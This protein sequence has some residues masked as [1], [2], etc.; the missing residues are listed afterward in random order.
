MA[1]CNLDKCELEA[2]EGEDRCILHCQKG[3][4]PDD[5]HRVGFLNSFYEELI[6][7]IVNYIFKHI[8]DREPLQKSDVRQH[9]LG[10]LK[11]DVADFLRE[12]T[13]VFTQIFF[14]ERDSRDTFDYKPALDKIG[15]I[16]FNYC[17][18]FLSSLDLRS[19]KLFFQDCV[20]HRFWYLY[21]HQILENVNQVLY[22]MC[23]FK[24]D[25]STVA[26]DYEK[27]ELSNSIFCNCQFQK[28]I[29][30]YDIKLKGRL[31]RNIHK[32]KI[33]VK[34]IEL[35]N[36]TFEDKS[37]LNNFTIDEFVCRDSLFNDK[38][39]FKE[40]KVNSFNI[41][42]TN[43]F[44]LV[45]CYCTSFNK[46]L[47]KKSI[48]EDFVNFENCEFGLAESPENKDYMAI[49]L[50]DTMMSFTNFRHAK[51]MSGL[52]LEHINLK[53]P[54][55]FLN[56]IISASNTNRDTFRTIKY[57]FDRIGNYIEANRFYE[58]EMLKYKEELRTAGKRSAYFLLQ[59]Y[60][61]T[62]NYG[63]SYIRPAILT[64]IASIIY[65]LLILSYERNLLYSIYPPLNTTIAVISG[66]LNGIARHILPLSKVLKEG[67]EFIS[68]IFY[69][70]FTT[71]VWLI[72][73]AIKRSTKR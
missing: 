20:F 32:K 66:S 55:N 11:S 68:L 53:E 7:Y 61:L 56:V 31:F 47:I 4:Y 54:P 17:E 44:K 25:I 72:I 8:Y 1:K 67:M 57:S 18:F 48:F 33:N 2:F 21:D 41:D 73:L 30:L 43:F 35:I 36:C 16:H 19:T 29:S 13:V 22:Q 49:F 63:Q 3:E 6:E 23:E 26:G 69:I 28:D 34:R 71:F 70:L 40:N 12:R 52:D 14:P 24:E 37:I 42:N 51:F 62:S 45:D 59:L 38:L 5:W 46:F 10:N 50:Y 64:L 60:E 65:W 58:R 9:L 27:P 15:K 39:E